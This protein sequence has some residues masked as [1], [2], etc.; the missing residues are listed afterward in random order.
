M[1]VKEG[2]LFQPLKQVRMVGTQFQWNCD[3]RMLQAMRPRVTF[4]FF[5]D[6]F[7]ELR[8]E[9]GTVLDVLK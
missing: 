4:P 9:F 5:F 3:R 6:R 1:Q 2:E 7:P 8:S